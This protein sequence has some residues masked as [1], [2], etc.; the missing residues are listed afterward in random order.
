[1]TAEVEVRT[2]YNKL[3]TEL[4]ERMYSDSYLSIGGVESTGILA[5]EA[6]I[7]GT[8]VVLD[9]GSGVGGPALHLAKTYGCSVTGLD[10]VELNVQEAGNRAKA[11]KLDHLA[12]F[13]VGDATDM[14]FD[15]GLFD[16][17]WGQDAWCHVPD[18]D[19]LIE[20]C[21]RVIKPGGTIAFSDWLQVGEM[22]GEYLGQVLSA[23]ASPNLATPEDYFALLKKHGFSIKTQADISGVFID[24]YREIIGKLESMKAEISE[25]ISPKVYTIMLDK[26]LCILEAFEGKKMGGGKVIAKKN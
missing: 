8:S 12:K 7:D 13:E 25:K 16:V 19:K 23:I 10:I 15:D 3:G 18:K 24:Q 21:A 20:E 14:P 1:M 5:T 22:K 17:V 4:I 9:V 26:N 2:N 11:R 6:G